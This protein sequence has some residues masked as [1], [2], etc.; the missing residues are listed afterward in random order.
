MDGW[1]DG[2]TDAEADVFRTAKCL[3]FGPTLHLQAYFICVKSMA[4]M[5]ISAC[6]SDHL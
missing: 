4:S 3:I 2:Q 6:S 5:F 1:T